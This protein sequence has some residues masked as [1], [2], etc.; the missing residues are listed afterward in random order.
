MTH[1]LHT[2][3]AIRHALSVAWHQ[4][5]TVGEEIFYP[6]AWRDERLTGVNLHGLPPSTSQPVAWLSRDRT[7]LEARREIAIE[8]VAADL[9]VSLSSTRG[10]GADGYRVLTLQ[11]AARRI[12]QE[13]GGP[14]T[15]REKHT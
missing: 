15:E 11:E 1:R 13:E 12:W 2:Q 7:A 14:V 6:A 10:G 8:R 5:E 4:T 9:D 3:A